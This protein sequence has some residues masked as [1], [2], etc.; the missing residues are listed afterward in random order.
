MSLL[1]LM[2]ILVGIGVIL[3]V[4]NAHVPMDAKIKKILNVVVIVAVMI[5]LLYQFGFLPMS[6]DIKVPKVK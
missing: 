6:E 3:Y 2:A 5:W 4:V 1:K